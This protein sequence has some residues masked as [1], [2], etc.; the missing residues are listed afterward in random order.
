M[1]EQDRVPLEEHKR[2][3]EEEWEKEQSL[4]IEERKKRLEIEA[5]F[6]LLERECVR[7]KIEALKASNVPILE[8]ERNDLRFRLEALQ[9][10]LPSLE[11]LDHLQHELEQS[12]HEL[13]SV[14]SK[15]SRASFWSS[16]AKEFAESIED[17]PAIQGSSAKDSNSA[18]IETVNA[19]QQEIQ[20]TFGRALA[21]HSDFDQT[22]RARRILIAQWVLL[23][24]LEIT[25]VVQ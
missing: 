12:R 3:Y 22:A 9:Q 23:R 1:N 18:V 21:G 7:L 14:Q 2:F 11:A 17:F 6:E 20:A 24:W 13:Q 10:R 16:I 5:K 4:R 19:W 25:A 8:A 15:I